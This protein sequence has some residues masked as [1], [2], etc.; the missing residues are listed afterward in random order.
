[1]EIGIGGQAR[2]AIPVSSLLRP[3][4]NTVG[5]YSFP[6][7]EKAEAQHLELIMKRIGLL[8][9]FFSNSHK[10]CWFWCKQVYKVLEVV[11][12]LSLRIGPTLYLGTLM[13]VVQLG[14]AHYALRILCK[15][16]EVCQK[17][18]AQVNHVG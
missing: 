9:F 14:N 18:H 8:S 2:A 1:M 3:N 12:N 5:C 10:N 17:T 6:S 15:I 4:S 16:L 13:D 11:K 7:L